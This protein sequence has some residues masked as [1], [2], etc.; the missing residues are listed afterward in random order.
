MLRLYGVKILRK[1][2]VILTSHSARHPIYH[3]K[4]LSKQN[5]HSSDNQLNILR[6]FLIAAR[7]LTHR[8]YVFHSQ[9]LS[10][11]SIDEILFEFWLFTK[12]AFQLIC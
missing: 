7:N 8:L 3:K 12:L 5:P 6:I 10:N 2:N 11:D 9:S 1:K 4:C